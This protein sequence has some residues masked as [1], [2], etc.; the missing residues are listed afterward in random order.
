M[1]HGNTLVKTTLGLRRMALAACVLLLTL[2]VIV[3]ALHAQTLAPV[4][5]ESG[6]VPETSSLPDAP[7]PVSQQSQ[8]AQEEGKQ[9]KRIL[10]IMPNFKAVDAN[11]YLPPLSVKGKFGGF[12]EDSFDFSSFVWIGMLSGIDQ[13]KK[14][15]KEFHQGG[16]GYGRYYWHNFVDQTDENLWTEF[17]LPSVLHED[18][19]YYTLG[20]YSGGEH[21]SAWQRAGYSLSRLIITR[22]DSGGESFNYAEV[23]GAGAA[24]GISNAYY[25]RQERNWTRVGQRWALNAGLDGLTM[26]FREFWPDLNRIIFHNHF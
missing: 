5:S 18:P 12:T 1:Q 4:A 10:Y 6:T 19:R 14:D 3:P 11:T 22:T 23:I 7:T 17:L 26:T 25:P 8:P 9:S 21:H 24:A 2:S 15:T 13:A 20:R 16:A